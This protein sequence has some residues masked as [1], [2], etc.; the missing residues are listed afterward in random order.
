MQASAA[1]GG[2]GGYLFLCTM[3]EDAVPDEQSDGWLGGCPLINNLPGELG[4]GVDTP[5][6]HCISGRVWLPL[7]FFAHIF[8]LACMEY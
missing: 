5:Q 1:I 7:K 2:G 6:L 8:N 4:S 3:H